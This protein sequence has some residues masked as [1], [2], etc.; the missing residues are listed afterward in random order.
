MKFTYNWLKDFVDLKI[1]PERLAE[2]LTM[3]GLEVVSLERKGNDVV[4][5]AEVTSNRPDWLSI[6]GVAREVAAI[7]GSK[8]KIP[9]TDKIRPSAQ[10]GALKIILE[11][12]KD[13]PLYTAKI[14]RGIRVG[15]SPDWLRERLEA[16]GCRSVNS[17]V[18][19]T[20]YIL[21]ESG[22][23]L[24]AFD[25][26]K[27]NKSGIMVRR[28]QKGEKITT[29][30]GE[31]KELSPQVLV[32]ADE[33]RPV[34]IAGIMGGKDTEVSETTKNI[35]LEAAV[36]NPILVRRGK[37]L[38]G[39]ASESAYRFERSVD[40]TYTEEAALT[41]VNLIRKL[42]GG[43]Y[44]LSNTTGRVKISA[45][46]INLNLVNVTRILGVKI[47]ENRIKKILGG[48]GL[49]VILRGKGKFKV[50]IP[51][52]RSDLNIEI[53][54]IEEI[55]RIFGYNNITATAP[56]VAGSATVNTA[57]DLV[58]GVKNILAGLGLNEVI[59]YSLIDK[60]LLQ[61]SG[62]TT[63]APVEILNPLS[64][65]QEILRPSLIPSL[66]RCIAYNLNQKQGSV[67]IF[68]VAKVFSPGDKNGPREELALSL[69][70]CGTR[71]WLLEQGLVKDKL[72]VLHLKGITETLFRRLGIE[73]YRFRTS[74]NNNIEVFL[75]AKKIGEFL[76]LAR[77][78]LE[79]FD[80]KNKEVAVAQLNL[81]EILSQLNLTRHFSP[82]PVYPGI[83]RDISLILKA[84][85][86][87]EDL[88]AAIK[89][90]A[91]DLLERVNIVDYYQG[92]QIP[93][94][95][96]GLTISCFYHS[97]RRTLIEEEVSPLHAAICRGLEEKFAVKLR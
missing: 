64:R 49:K 84:D 75:G 96:K 14:I 95:Y 73:N 87:A 56:A 33:R 82:L 4:F 6:L 9:V 46:N 61:D 55:A 20:N 51:A 79:R 60:K 70:L 32:I 47:A 40:L 97:T 36:F 50:T 63:S 10:S 76:Q 38:L 65:E 53:D 13:C 93:P 78:A 68:E 91:T 7:T 23:P 45:K 31:I 15:P 18:D 69:A 34:A 44:E 89:Q 41:A 52:V 88:L 29:I 26:D 16:V 67:S 3:A 42:T 90:Y 81:E 35:L 94:G 11:D 66:V 83:F 72:G 62:I 80:I 37:R 21:F 48:L 12:R 28:G 2:Q 5:E 30:D 58:S 74:G 54:L 86:L 17:I 27:L 85:I 22:Q 8:L 1:A 25:W 59:T 57:M 24:H 77:G 39:L 92:K 19:I 71:S 43:V